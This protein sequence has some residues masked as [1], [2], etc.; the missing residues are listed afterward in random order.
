MRNTIIHSTLLTAALA[1]SPLAFAAHPAQTVQDSGAKTTTATKSDAHRMHHHHMR[2]G[3]RGGHHR[4]SGLHK[5]DLTDTQK[6]SIKELRRD[7][8]KQ[9]K[10]AWKTLRDKRMALGKATPGSADYQRAADDLAHASANAASARV[11]RQAEL[12][13]KIHDI[14]TPEQRTRLADMRAKR[15]ERM[16]AWRAKHRHADKQSVSKAD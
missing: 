16:Q 1:L 8:F 14:L 15:M 7:S 10:P 4:M 9:A 11:L 5:L 12:R 13:K 2:R 6:S 3:F